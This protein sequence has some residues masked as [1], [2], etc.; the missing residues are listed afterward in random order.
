MSPQINTNLV[1][2]LLRCTEAIAWASIFPYAYFMIRSFHTVKE[3][4]VAFYASLL[5]S[6]FT[7]SEFLACMIWAKIADRIGRKPVLIL[8]TFGGMIS[9]I[10]FGTSKS[11]VIALISRAIGG[12][13]NPNNT[14]VQTCVAEL[15]KEKKDQPKA[16]TIV[17][18]LRALG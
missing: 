10:A 8:G 14:V 5:V 12:F 7:L 1:I 17:P 11:L 15:V 13:S 18:Y 4:D 6:I 2:G 3:S 16:F 9:A